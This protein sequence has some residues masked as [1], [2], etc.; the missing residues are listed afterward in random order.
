ME[1]WKVSIIIGLYNVA[2]Y[3]RDKHLSCILNQSYRNL[4]II[5]VN[6]GSTDETP[7]L[8]EELRVKDQ[9]IIIINKEN[10]GL[11]SARN[12]GLAVATGDY[13][14][15]YD[16]DDE[17]ETT[18]LE[19]AM[20]NATINDNDITIFGYDDYDV[21]YKT[22]TNI[23]YEPKLMQSNREIAD[24]Y[25]D[26]LLGLQYQNGFMWNKVYKR[27]FIEQNNIRFGDAFRIQ[28]DELF[29]LK[30]YRH[31]VRVELI[32]D[33]LYH[34]YTYNTGNNRSKYI[35]NR[36]ELYSTI[37]DEFLSLYS[38]WGLED[39][40]MLSYV[41]KRFYS[42]I[43]T[44]LN[45]NTFHPNSGLN[46]SERKAKILQIMQESDTQFCMDYMRDHDLAPT[47][48]YELTNWKAIEEESYILFMIYHYM[49]VAIDRIRWYVRTI[50]K[51][52]TQ[53]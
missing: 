9:R 52:L 22:L 16:V 2:K 23:A 10:G 17:C 43:L 50:L 51:L 33:V 6:D 27:S 12:A 41:Y 30:A 49:N 18:L 19:T 45:F 25:V 37:K 7:A 47:G 14:W 53:K 26:Y 1:K 48:R 46:K 44:V 3:L 13:L 20:H 42:N 29:N 15:F 31:A 11:G 40:R 35:P 4:E 21:K 28:Q 39:D 38:Y 32:P 5:L 24:N 34:Y 36:Y 8:C